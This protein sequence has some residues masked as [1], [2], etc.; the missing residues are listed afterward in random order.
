M[1]KIANEI[2][3]R[4]RIS[5]FI[6][7]EA[8]GRFVGFVVGIWTSTLFTK[9]VYEKRGLQNLFGLN[10]RK[11]VVVNTA[12]EWVQFLFSAIAGFIVLELINYFFRH[13]LY[14]PIWEKMKEFWNNHVSQK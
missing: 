10:P 1:K 4:D 3:T 11:Q 9:I 7:N 12:P 14:I 5:E 13:K 2:F 6:V 8:I